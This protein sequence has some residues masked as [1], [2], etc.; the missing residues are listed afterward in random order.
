ML[1]DRC[2]VRLSVG[3]FCLSVHTGILWQNSLVHQDETSRGGRPRLRPH[4]LTWGPSS[5][6]KGAQLAP[7]FSAHVYRGQIYG[8][9]KV[10][11]GTK[12]ASP[13]T[14]LC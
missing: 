1:S 3:L 8:W 9:I 13:R 12:V 6:T 5:P 14:T 2:P 11:L 10:P 4:C 7:Q